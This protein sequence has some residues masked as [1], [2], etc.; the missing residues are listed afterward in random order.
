M[1]TTTLALFRTQE[2]AEN[3]INDLSG[4][5]IP[6]KDISI[7]VKDESTGPNVAEGVALGLG[8]GGILIGITSLLAGIGAVVVPGIGGILMAGPV[9]MALTGVAA[10]GLLGGL[11]GLG[12]PKQ[13]ALVYEMDIKIGG[14]LL[15]IPT[16]A[17]SEA[18]VKGILQ[19]HHASQILSVNKSTV[20][21]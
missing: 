17:G 19:K 10:G 16:T 3:A 21:A 8:T 11:M 18:T 13:D 9:A 5:G 1:D 20:L 4:I 12:L 7:L 15:G 2:S 14:I 6:S